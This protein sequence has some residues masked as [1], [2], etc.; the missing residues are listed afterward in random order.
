MRRATIA[1]IFRQFRMKAKFRQLLLLFSIL[2]GSIANAQYFSTGE[3][4][5]EMQWN[6]IKTR[7]FRVVFECGNESL[8]LNYAKELEA[9][10]CKLG[11]SLQ[12]S[13]KS[14]DVILHSRS[15]TANALVSW[16]PSRMEFYTRPPQDSYAQPWPQQLALHEYRHVVQTSRLY[17]S[18]TR[19]LGYMFGEQAPAA[20]LGLYVPLW[21]LEGDAVYA[22]TVFS[23]SG[24][25]RD[26]FFS[27]PLRAQLLEYGAFGYDK[28]YFGS[29]RD[30]VPDHYVLG[31]HIVSQA[32][33]EFGI[34]VWDSALSYVARNP[35][36][37]LAF[38]RG[39]KKAT[40]FGKINIYKRAMRSLT[41]G[42]KSNPDFR[43]TTAMQ[44]KAKKH[45]SYIRAN[46]LNDSAVFAIRQEFGYPDQFVLLNTKGREKK[47]FTPGRYLP[48]SVQVTGDVCVYT[49]ISPDVRWANRNYTET[50]VYNLTSGQ[51]SV[52]A[53]KT[54]WFSP[55][56]SP[57]RNL[58]AVIENDTR[59][60]SC[61]LISEIKTGNIVFRLID[62]TGGSFITPR[63]YPDGRNLAVV[64]ITEQ[65]KSLLKIDYQLKTTQIL[66]PSSFSEI[67]D[68]LP[69]GDTVLY[70]GGC[71]DK[72]EIFAFLA[73]QNKHLQLTK[74]L[75]GAAYP[76]VKPHSDFIVYSVYTANG[77][78]VVTKPIDSLLWQT[79]ETC[80][81]E[82]EVMLSGFA[83]QEGVDQLSEVNQPAEFVVEPY[84]KAGHLF[85]FHSYGPV[86]VNADESTINPGFTFVSQNLTG[87]SLATL[88]Y[89][90]DPGIKE[91]RFY[92]NYTYRGFYPVFTLESDYRNRKTIQYHEN[93]PYDFKWHET[94]VKLACN[95]PFNLSSGLW[96]RLL[97]PEIAVKANF[98]QE[99]PDQ[100]FEINNKQYQ[101]I[102]YRLYFANYYKSGFSD[103]YPKFGQMVDLNYK[104]ASLSGWQA[105]VE[106][107]L[108]FPGFGRHHGI[109]LYAGYEH[110]SDGTVMYARNIS[111]PRGYGY[112]DD[113][114]ITVS[115]LTY[116][117]PIL[118]PDISLGPLAY[119]KRIKMALFADLA[120]NYSNLYS[121]VGVEITNDFHFLRF[122]APVDAGFRVSYLPEDKTATADFLIYINLSNF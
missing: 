117:M 49:V 99:Y 116:K 24:R 61:L 122:I 83:K 114:E 108:F 82:P 55:A 111:M 7:N 17:E 51:D 13:P 63:W 45:I 57:D 15:V 121:S 10:S 27:V 66:I 58:L 95:I 107:N 18:S 46:Q 89:E 41:H 5:S 28:A 69:L 32:R 71:P 118:Y 2:Y 119:I 85:N 25:G 56:L 4:P 68:P 106:G 91:D 115:T 104:M 112:I 26:P 3:D 47:V 70:V 72:P 30:F 53:R 16:A 103:L 6:Q 44:D 12:A 23:E 92:L 31:Y 60:N 11:H 81:S 14:I 94:G 97:F 110:R 19:F 33:N 93:I 1:A 9:A 77:Y 90:Y 59:A 67:Y 98:L 102:S 73:N 76:S 88:G 78:R 96:S 75:Y 39:L 113:N 65:G 79:P 48:E 86:S 36:H 101:T 43:D 120:F 74:T 37:P 109:K 20:V 54:R 42:W 40:G 38:S 64:L 105:A 87:T 22:E 80:M 34:M 62:S 50:H 52:L 21:F 29:Y 8:A 35:F 84:S 100:P